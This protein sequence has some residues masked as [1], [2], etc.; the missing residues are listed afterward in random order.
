MSLRRQVG[1]PTPRPSATEGPLLKAVSR[2]LHADSLEQLERTSELL[3]RETPPSYGPQ[4]ERERR[5]LAM[6]HFSLWTS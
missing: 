4:G 1:F 6:L 5:L 2:L 3:A